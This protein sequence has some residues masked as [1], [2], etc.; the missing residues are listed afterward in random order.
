MDN[1]LSCFSQG[2]SH[3]S[4]YE[5]LRRREAPG[6]HVR[7]FVTEDEWMSKAVPFICI[8][9]ISDALLSTQGAAY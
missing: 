8:L 6:W 1:E 9:V 3:V 5:T 2:K 4:H 7:I